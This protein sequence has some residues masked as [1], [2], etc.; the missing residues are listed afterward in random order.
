MKTIV[1]ICDKI[2]GSVVQNIAGHTFKIMRQYMID[3]GIFST[4]DQAWKAATSRVPADTTCL[5]L[6]ERNSSARADSTCLQFYRAGSQTC[7]KSARDL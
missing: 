2:P 5:L 4:V 7:K 1:A 3:A 6:Y